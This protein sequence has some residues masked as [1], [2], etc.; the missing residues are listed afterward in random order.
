VRQSPQDKSASNELES[1]RRKFQSI[2]KRQD[3]LLYLTLHLLLNLAE[4]LSIEV[5]MLKRDIISN[6]ILLLDRP[7]Q[8]LI[9]L[10]LS[11]IKKLS[12]FEENISEMLLVSFNP[13]FNS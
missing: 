6:L 11:F 8:D 5:K 10:V 2:M 1:Q 3:Q 7:T 13:F 4:D 12:I 9:A